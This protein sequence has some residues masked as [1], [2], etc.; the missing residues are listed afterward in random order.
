MFIL[1]SGSWTVVVL[2]YLENCW[3]KKMG[4]GV[5]ILHVPTESKTLGMESGKQG[6]P[7]A[8]QAHWMNM[9]FST[10]EVP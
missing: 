8:C 10:C 1:S 3:E 2:T 5:G 6:D 7:Y 4:V 9:Y